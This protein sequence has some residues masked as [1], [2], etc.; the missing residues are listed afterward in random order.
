[1]SLVSALMPCVEEYR[2]TLRSWLSP[3]DY[4]KVQSDVH[5]NCQE[6]TGQW[7]LNDAR[8][9][10]WLSGTSSQT[11]FCPGI[12]GAGKTVIAS[13]VVNH[14]R[15]RYLDNSTSETDR[16]GVAVLYCN[17][18]QQND[19][20]SHDL[21]ASL[22]SQLSLEQD[23][24]P[25]GIRTLHDQFRKR[26]TQPSSRDIFEELRSSVTGYSTAFVV[27][28][29]LDEC[30]DD[31]TRKD[32]L[33]KMLQLQ[34]IADVRLMLTSRPN[35]LPNRE[36][37]VQLPI[38]ASEE[39]VRRYLT[40][41]LG[42]L[43]EVVE[44]DAV[45]QSEI[46]LRV[47]KASDGM[48]LLAQLY[49]G[50]L[51]DKHTK[52]A[53]TIELN[54]MDTGH[55]GLDQAYKGAFQRI[56]SSLSKSLLSWVVIAQRLLT[57]DEMQHALAIEP[58][59]S[60]LDLSNICDIQEV[61][62]GCAGLVVLDSVSQSI[63]LVHQTAKDYFKANISEYFPGAR[64]NIALN[65]LTYLSYE[66]LK[67]GACPNN[68]LLDMRLKRFPFLF[69]ASRFWVYHWDCMENKVEEPVLSL[70]LDQGLVSAAGQGALVLTNWGSEYKQRTLNRVTGMHLAAALD[71]YE[72]V[73]RL[74][75]KLSLNSTDNYGFTPLH[76]ATKNEYTRTVQSLLDGGADINLA[77]NSG[78]TPLHLA[79]MKGH[80]AIVTLLIEKGADIS[81]RDNGG[82]TP[83][84]WAIDTESDA[85]A[86][87]LLK[88][89]AQMEFLYC[90]FFQ[91]TAPLPSQVVVESSSAKKYDFPQRFRA[92]STFI[93]FSVYSNTADE[94]PGQEISPCRYERRIFLP[95]QFLSRMDFHDHPLLPDGRQSLLY[96]YYR[97][98][99]PVNSNFY[100]PKYEWSV[101]DLFFT[102][103]LR[104]VWIGN[105][106]IVQLLLNM[107]CSPC[108]GN[109]R[110]VMPLELAKRLEDNTS[111]RIIM[112]FW[113]QPEQFQAEQWGLTK[114]P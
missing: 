72:F 99:P 1:M 11:L 90:P 45:L 4:D 25:A 107:G 26:R 44:R 39:D 87:L 65:C 112:S 85:V 36:D 78:T 68:Q 14:L 58:G 19:Q 51:K 86:E 3:I 13:L 63:R 23:I 50:S 5:R 104:A 2:K 15:S 48:F 52:K 74:S 42:H 21:L 33:N 46:E 55:A 35:I 6:G 91:Y 100:F 8:F 61:V 34:E 57:V 22:L 54:K 59:T 113:N 41:Q 95:P 18:Q 88:K 70:L 82:G 94:E 32:L 53:I 83:L 20:A 111:T 24:V 43:S 17:Y 92:L 10:N 77:G 27:I 81:C 60:N 30:K 62:S 67:S 102:P 29:A 108:F 114:L 79:S 56:E 38:H 71:L 37:M 31:A 93:S 16:V 76:Y 47:S 12:P 66:E 96:D 64:N 106:R 69:Y 7:F 110:G 40:S 49:I 103:L 101:D 75:E 9:T 80:E 105:H 98:R 84:T 97:Y 28:D 109:S 89:G 73:P